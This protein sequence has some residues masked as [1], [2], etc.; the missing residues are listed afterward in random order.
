MSNSEAI[1]R[2]LGGAV[3]NWHGWLCRCP[4]HDDRR[5]SLSL[6]QG[7]DGRLLVHCFTGCDPREILGVLRARGMQIGTPITMHGC[8]QQVYGPDQDMKRST[9]RMEAALRL[10]KASQPAIRSLVEAYL[11]GRSIT[12]PLP[13]TLRYHPALK[14]PGGASWP[15]MVALVQNGVDGQPIGIHR[16]F[17]APDVTGKAPVSPDKMMLG[18]CIGGAVKLAPAGNTLAVTE[19]IETGMSVMT[20]TGISTWAALSAGGITRLVL[21]PLPL[22]REVLVAADNDE[23]GVGQ[24]A[25][26]AAARR[27][28]AEG[29]RVRIAMPPKAG[30][31]FNDIL[32]EGHHVA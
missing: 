32:C 14:H 28:L 31:D 3:R 19:G 7:D 29:R 16:T 8:H 5:P 24:R 30:T 4:I 10:W 27:W 25:A 17:L 20:A 1:A 21:P 12:L 15:G 18:S 23:N 6:A 22:A 26:Q 2:A 9:A 13:P 11:R